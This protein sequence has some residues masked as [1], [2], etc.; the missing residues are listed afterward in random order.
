M[1][2][3]KKNDMEISLRPTEGR[4]ISLVAFGNAVMRANAMLE[5]FE[6]EIGLDYAE[7]GF[8][9][10]SLYSSNPTI[11]IAGSGNE[12]KTEVFAS[13]IDAVK[14]T[15][16][17]DWS[18]WPRSVESL[19]CV[20]AVQDFVRITVD[21]SADAVF[22]YDGRAESTTAAS[23]ETL[24]KWVDDQRSNLRPI[25][26]L[27][28]VSGQL[29]SIN[30]HTRNLLGIWRSSD[31]RRFEC[32]FDDDQFEDARRLLGKSVVVSGLVL[33]G[34]VNR[35]TGVTSIREVPSTT[36]VSTQSFY[37]SIPDIKGGLSDSEYWSIVRGG[38]TYGDG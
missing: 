1:T 37:G 38:R 8:E 24:K 2:I 27:G 23:S 13:V 29:D 18:S 4:R 5:S 12:P 6:N 30:V 28:D 34:R 19:T 25:R 7:P 17:D 20:E 3:S 10:A 16:D 36:S 9:L 26:A 11:V 35:V 32:E 33:E 14:S 15:A 31:N 22:E 21:A